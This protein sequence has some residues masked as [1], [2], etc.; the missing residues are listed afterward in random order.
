MSAPASY[1][2]LSACLQ[3]MAAAAYG[4][5][6]APQPKRRRE[7]RDRAARAMAAA[8]AGCRS[9]RAASQQSAA[10]SAG[11]AGRGG[12]GGGGGGG[13]LCGARQGGPGTAAPHAAHAALRSPAAPKAACRHRMVQASCTGLQH[14]VPADIHTSEAQ[15]TPCS[16]SSGTRPGAMAAKTELP[17]GATSV[18]RGGSSA[19]SRA[20]WR[21]AVGGLRLAA[22]SARASS[23][24]G[25]AAQTAWWAGGQ[26][27]GE[28]CE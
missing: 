19:S 22:A 13:E 21:A 6:E 20:S 10:R 3:R 27:A 7:A 23:V 16:L 25:Y 12:G 5:A 14:G 9:A 18:S 17:P 8:R 4:A 26:G 15:P 24:P 2:A 28:E 11:R 1:A